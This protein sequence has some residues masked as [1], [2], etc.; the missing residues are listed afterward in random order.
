MSFVSVFST[1]FMLRALIEMVLL[2]A[3]TGVVGVFVSLRRLEFMTDA[4][5]HTV[6]PGIAIAFV[7]ELP[8]IFGAFVSAVLSV[9]VLTAVVSKRRIDH[10]AALVA[11]LASFFAV[12]VIVVSRSRSYA[13]DLT[14][15]LFGRILS[16]DRAQILQTA[17][18]A[19][20]VVGTLGLFA[21][22]LIF[23]AFDPE[24]AA[25][26]GYQIVWLDVMLNVAIALV[27]VAALQAVGTM[28][29]ITLIVTP[30]AI[31]RMFTDSIAK[32]ILISCLVS[33]IVSWLALSLSYQASVD[34]GWRIAAGPAIA[35]GLTGVF[36]LVTTCRQVLRAI[37][38]RGKGQLL[39][40]QRI[41]VATG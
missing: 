5:S 10:D 27:V 2:A 6:F 25:A 20:V 18:I 16:V 8:L 35:V 14:S 17:A 1:P 7:L 30:A 39:G 38:R 15:L 22:E 3:L 26:A 11:I 40:E 41:D 23:R 31:A 24:G 21:K 37:R 28:L 19:V 33:A 29:V 34:Y 9:L 32:M 36:V 12:G 4:L 13:S